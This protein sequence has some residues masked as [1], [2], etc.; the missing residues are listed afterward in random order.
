[1]NNIKMKWLP[2]LFILSVLGF[3]TYYYLF[4]GRS[5]NVKFG[6]SANVVREM[7][8][9]P[10]IEPG[11]KRVK[12]PG[13][14]GGGRWEGSDE[15]NGVVHLWKMV[16]SHGG[17]GPYL[18]HEEIDAFRKNIDSASYWQLNISSTILGDSSSI[19]EG[20]LWL[21]CNG[22]DQSEHSLSDNSLDSIFAKWGINDFAKKKP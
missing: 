9:V 14:A 2:L 19:R 1:M 6:K 22:C 11:M 15:K 20:R 7:V 21:H 5:E 18:L 3:L 16:S 8:K 10:I 12:L 17:D 13:N 4:K